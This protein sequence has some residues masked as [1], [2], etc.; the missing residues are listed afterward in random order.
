MLMAEYSY[1]TDIEVQREEAAE[2]TAKKVTK[3]VT[4]K[5]EEKNLL[6]YVEKVSIN[7]HVTA[8]EA[9]KNLGKSY[10]KFLEVKKK[11][12][13]TQVESQEGTFSDVCTEIVE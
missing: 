5:V 10:E 11:Y 1:E 9:C 12:S 2:K 4:D 3:E 8:E 6:E 13:Q 7:F